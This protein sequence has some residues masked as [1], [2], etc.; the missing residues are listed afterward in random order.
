MMVWRAGECKASLNFC[1]ESLSQTN[2]FDT[3]VKEILLLLL[4]L[5]VYTTQVNSAFRA[6]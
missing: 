5:L 1:V 6:R 3:R 4:L 2:C